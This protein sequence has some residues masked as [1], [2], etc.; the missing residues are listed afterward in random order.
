MR[1]RDG[2]GD[3]IK[4][5][6]HHR[7]TGRLRS[8]PIE[9]CSTAYWISIKNQLYLLNDP[10]LGPVCLA[11]RPVGALL[12]FVSCFACSLL[13]TLHPFVFCK[14]SRNLQRRRF[15]VQVRI[16]YPAIEFANDFANVTCEVYR[17]KK[18][19][20]WYRDTAKNCHN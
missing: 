8:Q 16:S 6:F 7:R 1:W 2:T 19:S 12:F 3:P 20:F 18:I 10:G 14:S 4:C 15:Q 13:F 17:I 11:P 9:T 5:K